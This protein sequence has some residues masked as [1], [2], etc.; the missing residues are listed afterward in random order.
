ME[1]VGRVTRIRRYPVKSMRGEDLDAVFVSYA[2][3]AGDRVYAFVDETNTGNFPWMTA[4]QKSE[5]LLFTPRFTRPPDISQQYPEMERYDVT[6]E[7]PE[8]EKFSI[9]DP[10]FEKHLEKRFSKPLSLRFSE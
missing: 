4:R 7:T 9:R 6:V 3:L 5:L 2:G 1:Q 8:G 10:Q